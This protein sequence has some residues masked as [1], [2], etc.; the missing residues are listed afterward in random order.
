MAR[1]KIDDRYRKR[2]KE[3]RNIPVEF[4]AVIIWAF[5]NSGPRT[6]ADYS[7][8]F[9][10]MEQWNYYKIDILFELE[11]QWMYESIIQLCPDISDVC[12][13]EG[14]SIFLNR[15]AGDIENIERRF[16]EYRKITVTS[17]MIKNLMVK[18][19]MT[20][21][22][23][24]W[25]N[26]WYLNERNIET[27]MHP[28]NVAP[29]DPLEPVLLPKHEKKAGWPRSL[30]GFPEWIQR[31]LEMISKQNA[32][33]G[34]PNRRKPA[35]KDVCSAE[36]PVIHGG[37]VFPFNASGQEIEKTILAMEVGGRSVMVWGYRLLEFEPDVPYTPFASHFSPRD[38]DDHARKLQ[39]AMF[40]ES[41][42]IVGGEEDGLT[43]L[44][45]VL[46][47][48]VRVLKRP[49]RDRSPLSHLV[50]H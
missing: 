1:E 43:D 10:A 18:P 6:K 16:K 26:Y 21:E 22:F 39:S 4:R 27:E 8:L 44:P 32:I 45:A 40:R 3:W 36:L 2:W 38:S 41:D 9:M 37:R 7:T 15:K 42:W 13:F 46:N 34:A 47:E 20:K 12:V 17:E 33:H 48:T 35:N 11:I 25:M 29:I 50:I 5:L 30:P 23:W 24:S 31:E 14:L 28:T 49:N 19:M